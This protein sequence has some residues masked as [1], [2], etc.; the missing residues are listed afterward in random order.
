MVARVVAGDGYDP[1]TGSVTV[2]AGTS[3]VLTFQVTENLD[4]G[5]KVDL[6]VIDGRTGLAL[7]SAP[8]HCSSM[9]VTVKD[10]LD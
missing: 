2:G 10:E 3:S 8:V 1:D 4:A 6:Q 5:T 9:P 7:A